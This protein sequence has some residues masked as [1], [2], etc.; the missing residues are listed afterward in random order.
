VTDIDHGRRGLLRASGITVLSV[1]AV[2]ILAGCEKMA[3]PKPA[4][5]LATSRS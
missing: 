4:T 5:P 3:W 2:A 1:S